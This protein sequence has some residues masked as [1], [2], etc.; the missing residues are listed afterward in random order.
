MVFRL[1]T[2]S[3][4]APD[5]AVRRPATASHAVSYPLFDWLRFVLASVVALGHGKVID[6]PDAGFLAVQVFLALSGWLIGGILLQTTRADLPRFFFNRATRIWI[7]YGIA[8]LLLYSVSALRDPVNARWLEHLAYDV[9][10]THNLYSLKPD[11]ATALPL[12]PLQGTG[13]HFWSIGVEEQFYLLAPL[14]MLFTPLGKS[15]KLWLAIAAFMVV[16]GGWFGAI[17]LGVSAAIAR[18]DFGNW[19][20]P[21][22]PAFALVAA[23]TFALLV[24]PGMPMRQIAPIFAIAVIL[25]LAVE[26][27][28]SQLGLLAGGLSYPL[29]LNHWIPVFA[30]HFVLSRVGLE[31]SDL[32]ETLAWLLAVLGAALHFLVI[33]RAIQRH[34]GCVFTPALGRG[35]GLTAYG[36]LLSGVVLGTLSWGLPFWG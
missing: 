17:S 27:P 19:H 30:V 4:A 34:R 23:A 26:G 24:T 10:F 35:L 20:L 6:W 9:T 15:L 22:R 21:W 13:N 16:T 33:D 14:V 25:L 28:R 2:A 7:P 1:P 29:Y 3:D 18:R 5:L 31:T 12:M 32:W 36:L 8:I 11:A